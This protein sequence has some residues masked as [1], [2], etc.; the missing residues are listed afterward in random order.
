MR[1][2][3]LAS[4]LLVTLTGVWVI[5]GYT[6]R[7]GPTA[8]DKTLAAE[9]V[10]KALD[11]TQAI[12]ALSDRGYAIAQVLRGAE[13]MQE[14]VGQMAVRREVAL[15]LLHQ[16]F[17]EALQLEDPET[18]GGEAFEIYRTALDLDRAVAEKWRAEIEDEETRAGF[19][20]PW[21]PSV[22]ETDPSG[23]AE[24][25]LPAALA[26]VEQ[27]E[28]P[29][30][31]AR[32]KMSL[33]EKLA[34]VRVSTDTALR[35]AEQAGTLADRSGSPEDK[36]QVR[37]SQVRTH[38]T[39]GDTEPVRPLLSQAMAAVAGIAEAPYSQA[40]SY[41]EI[42]GLAD[43]E[44]IYWR[45]PVYPTY[46]QAPEQGSHT[47]IAKEARSRAL[48]AAMALTEPDMKAMAVGQVAR[49][50][51][52]GA[53]SLKGDQQSAALSE[54]L[55][56]VRQVPA[57]GNERTSLLSEAAGLAR[58]TD[59]ALAGE[60]LD[61]ALACSSPAGESLNAALGR[62][63]LIGTAAFAGDKRCWEWAASDAKEVREADWVA[64]PDET[65][66]MP[67]DLARA[68]AETAVLGATFGSGDLQRAKRF[69]QE[70]SKLGGYEAAEAVW[71]AGIYVWDP[72]LAFDIS[73][74]LLT[75]LQSSQAPVRG[76]IAALAA[77][78]AFA[79]HL[80]VADSDAYERALPLWDRALQ[81]SAGSAS[82]TDRAVSA[83]VLCAAA[84]AV[85]P[86]RTAAAA[87]AADE[88]LR[89]MEDQD[90][91]DQ[92]AIV[93][94]ALVAVGDPKAAADLTEIVGDPQARARV[95][96][97]TAQAMVFDFG[98]LRKEL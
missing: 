27:I 82:A 23:L 35:L 91:Q 14:K 41:L 84:A 67:L 17:L 21:G 13:G 55:E 16:A 10:R 37:I 44:D 83:A 3:L 97:T 76:C 24:K 69:V 42:A 57:E 60:L 8:E 93:V 11:D 90:L 38:V 28:D 61:E 47:D 73:G 39:L 20:V 94:C 77:V 54:A 86:D 79:H 81:L 72:S 52:R 45:P 53:R 63:G 70:H 50:Q 88:G 51:L 68:M 31:R 66:D 33:A 74:K 12:A 78:P 80:V 6:Q 19:D 15:D 7:S 62:A 5:T 36:A 22:D 1:R 48:R 96:L 2:W 49:A 30:E 9:L 75:R 64:G 95:R 59:L 71:S 46:G 58:K 18:P 34:G 40:T 85:D 25:D 87:Q 92:T 65:Q 89:A 56:T 98:S 43:G 4:V 29:M 32:A 26:A